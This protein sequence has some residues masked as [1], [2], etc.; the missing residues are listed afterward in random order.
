MINLK[1]YLLLILTTLVI[2]CSN[3][4]KVETTTVPT[5]TPETV[6]TVEPTA[7]PN[8]TVSN[9]SDIT[10]EALEPQVQEILNDNSLNKFT[11]LFDDETPITDC[12]YITYNGEIVELD[13]NLGAEVYFVPVFGE[14]K[15]NDVIGLYEDEVTD[16]TVLQPKK[17]KKA[18]VF[19]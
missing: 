11:A 7:S 5:L 3:Q 13:P 16:K 17:I 12:Y 19:Y 18:V 1:K 6:A 14:Y 10:K 8:E 4:K 2:G 9:D 15:K